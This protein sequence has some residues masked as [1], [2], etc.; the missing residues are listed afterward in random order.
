MRYY[1]YI[2]YS[3]GHDQFYYGQTQNLGS[4]LEKH[5]RG[6]VRSTK[7]YMPWLLYAYLELSSRSESMA[8][9]KKL[10]NLHG[11]ER[12]HDF[13]TSHQFVYKGMPDVGSQEVI[14]PEF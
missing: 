7:R 12:L 8:M 3:P 11:K 4:R 6:Q 9:E 2:L 1:T 10:K 5:N 13:I 14:G